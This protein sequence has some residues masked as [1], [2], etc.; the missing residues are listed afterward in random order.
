MVATTD[1]LQ[2]ESRFVDSG[3]CQTPVPM[4]DLTDDVQTR[5]S[6]EMH[7]LQATA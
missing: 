3:A 6:Q 5:A 7:V 1:R 2:R 4:E